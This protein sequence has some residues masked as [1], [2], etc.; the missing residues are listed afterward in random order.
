VTQGQG[1]PPSGS[2]CQPTA[3][4]ADASS[5]SGIP[6]AADVLTQLHY[7]EAVEALAEAMGPLIAEEF[8]GEPWGAAKWSAMSEKDRIVIRYI[9]LRGL[10]RLVN[11]CHR[12]ASKAKEAD[13]A[14]PDASERARDELASQAQELDMGYGANTEEPPVPNAVDLWVADVR[15]GINYPCKYWSIAA[16]EYRG[17]AGCDCMGIRE[18]REKAQA[19]EAQRAATEN[20]DAVHEGAVPQGCARKEQP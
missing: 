13:V 8:D 14:V 19:I 7:P 16:C 9:A 18:Y 12:Y 20:T 17:S 11:H 4:A 10:S 6:N 3:S 1:V 5:R 15:A 2:G